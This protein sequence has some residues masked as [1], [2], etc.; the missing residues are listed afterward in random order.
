MIDRTWVSAKAAANGRAF[1]ELVNRSCAHYERKGLA[2]IEKTPEPFRVLHRKG[3]LFDG[4]FTKK[5]QPD[6]KGV[7]VGGRCVCFECKHSETATIAASRV[8]E[9]QLRY[10]EEMRE[11]GAVSF[12]L[13]SFGLGGFYRVPTDI[14]ANFITVFH[15]KSATEEMLSEYRVPFIGG[16]VRF[17][18]HID[19]KVG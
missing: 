19:G 16:V 8:Q 18:D 2:K 13:V 9:N 15:R 6:Y 7:L 14:W 3:R 11:Y 4:I 1:E 12:V 17:L 10:L 5:A